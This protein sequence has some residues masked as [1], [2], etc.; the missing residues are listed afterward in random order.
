MG[1]AREGRGV[2]SCSSWGGETPFNWTDP[3]GCVVSP[4][5]NRPAWQSGGARGSPLLGHMWRETRHGT[6]PKGVPGAHRSSQSL[7]GLRHPG[8][9]RVG[10]GR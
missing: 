8:L 1:E 4:P 6:P 2:W 3:L 7:G 5:P 10:L 9:C